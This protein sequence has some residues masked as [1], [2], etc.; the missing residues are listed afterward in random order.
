ML[1]KIVL[2]PILLSFSLL[3]FAQGPINFSV[4]TDARQVIL[5]QQFEVYFTLTNANGS[6]FTPP[7][8]RYFD[9]ISGPNRSISTSNING[10]WSKEL[11]YTFILQP[12]TTGQFPVKSASIKADGKTLKTTSLT[13]EV[14]RRKNSTAKT[15][16]ELESEIGKDVFIKAITNVEEA[17]VGEQ[18]T[19]DYVVYTKRDI[20]NYNIIFESEYP[21][22]YAQEIRRYNNRPIKEV[23]DGVQYVTKILRRVALYPQQAGLLTVDPLEMEIAIIIDGQKNRRRS[24]FYTPEVTRIKVKTNPVKISVGSLPE[25]PPVSYSGAVGTYKLRANIP[26]T[27][28]STDDAIS[29]KM[30]IT[31]NGDVKQVQAPNLNLPADTFEVYE[32]KIL[33]ESVFETAGILNGKKVWEYLILPKKPGQFTLQ[34]EFTYYDVD[35]S[36]YVTLKG[37]NYP[38][39]VRKGQNRK[40]SSIVQEDAVNTQEDIRFIKTQT[41][42]QQR[43]EPFFRSPFFYSLFSFPLLLL[44]GVFVYQKIQ[45]KKSNV[46]LS[47]LKSQRARAQAKKRLEAAE[48][49]MKANKASGFYDEVSKSLFGYVCDKLQIPLS[50]LTKANVREKLKGLNV[51]DQHITRFMEIIKTCEMALFAGKDNSQ[52][53]QQ[54]YKDALEVVTDI[55]KEVG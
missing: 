46:D 39:Y 18:I 2:L 10:R 13:I 26:R 23:V 9:V 5:G 38:I 12:K 47:V 49:L 25:N 14:L 51:A 30:E 36:A 24:F 7:N 19:I 6:D 44:G 41:S 32:P 16:D 15:Q 4:S 20:E 55:E 27:N 21:G 42:L 53:M 29:V 43:S 17:K 31:G 37:N 3:A 34:P 33:D 22:F 54:T 28:V 1:K 50:Q 11:T 52:A 45:A 35:S 48:G 40:A 8:F